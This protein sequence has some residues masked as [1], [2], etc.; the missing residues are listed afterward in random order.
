VTIEKYHALLDDWFALNRPAGSRKRQGRTLLRIGTTSLEVCYSDAMGQGQIVLV[1]YFDMPAQGPRLDVAEQMLK[2]NFMLQV[3]GMPLVW[4]LNP[5]TGQ[6]HVTERVGLDG[7]TTSQL[8]A[9][10]AV[11]SESVSQW[12]ARVFALEAR[13]LTASNASSAARPV[14]AACRSSPFPVDRAARAR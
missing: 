13:E 7:L 2:A 12:A 4:S 14:K 8:S 11:F 6:V 9:R 10:L 1:A 3:M 5:R